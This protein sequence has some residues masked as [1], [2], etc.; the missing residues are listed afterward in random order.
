MQRPLAPVNYAITNYGKH[1]IDD[2]T[3]ENSTCL[4]M[5]IFA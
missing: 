2:I 1:Y 4:I 3:T 5:R